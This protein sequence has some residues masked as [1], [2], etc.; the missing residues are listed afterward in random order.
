MPSTIEGS[1][2]VAKE[3]QFPKLGRYQVI[4]RIASGGMAEVFL[5]QAVGAMGFQRLVA[6][7]LIHSNFTRD[8][9]FVKMFIDEA[10]IAM[11]LHHRNIVQVFD[12]DEERGTYFLAMEYVR[13]V[14]L[15]ELYERISAS[16]RWIEVPMALYL[17]AEICKG[18]HFA[19]TRTGADGK[20]LGIIHR[21]ISPQ[22]VL[23]SFEG[24]VKITDFGIATA[25]ERLHQTAAGI[26]KGKYAYMAPE[27]LD[28]ATVD[29]RVDVFSAGVLLYELLVGENPFAGASAVETI[30]AVLNTEVAAPSARGAMIPMRL[31][32]ICLRALAKK[33]EDRWPSTAA[34]ADALTELAMEL[35]YARKDMASGDAALANLLAQLFPEERAKRRGSD[36]KPIKL[37]GVESPSP[38][39]RPVVGGFDELDDADLDEPT[40]LRPQPGHISDVNDEGV[41]DRDTPQDPTRP[42]EFPNEQPHKDVI[43]EESSSALTVASYPPRPQVVEGGPLDP[44]W[45]GGPNPAH[46]GYVDDEQTLKP[47]IRPEGLPSAFGQ[48]IYDP[49]NT[50]MEG[51]VSPSSVRGTPNVTTPGGVQTRTTGQNASLPHH[52][53]SPVVREPTSPRNWVGFVLLAFA[54]VLFGVVVA[55]ALSDTSQ[56]AIVEVPL[57]LEST[58]PGAQVFVD[59]R[60]LIDR[61]P[62]E[63][64]IL[65]GTPVEVTFEL[66]GYD[67]VT[68]RIIADERR[69][70]VLAVQLPISSGPPPLEITPRRRAVTIR[71][72][73]GRWSAVFLEGRNL[74]PSPVTVELPVGTTNIEVVREPRGRRRVIRIRVPKTGP[75][76]IH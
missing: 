60:A 35:T 4:D 49:A 76:S 14:N 43:N 56:R 50:P 30:E 27:R 61:T 21:D 32:D 42:T 5:A 48:N 6:L 31:D 65:A 69:V 54:V 3:D 62:T 20:A 39:S 28:E 59:G 18:L 70:G 11:H 57:R 74:G 24:E 75:A 23:L 63:T 25:A 15:Y 71:P 66:P 53:P 17:V 58:P 40:I 33:P 8:P 26:V 51:S 37:P 55:I 16:D 7:K 45:M 72:Q 68:R 64:S 10:R 19:H 73:R 34:L 52:T 41:D 2:P 9:E 38:V 47:T 1:P 13:G 67:P 29:A 46:L 36:P 12:L 22:N 44:T